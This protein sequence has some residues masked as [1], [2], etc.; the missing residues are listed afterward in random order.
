MA[1]QKSGKELV[2]G[3]VPATVEFPVLS[4]G[5]PAPGD[6]WD[7]EA[8]QKKRDAAETAKDVAIDRK[9]VEEFERLENVLDA[10]DAE[11]AAQSTGG[12]GRGPLQHCRAE[13][14]EPLLRRVIPWGCWH[15]R[16]RMQPR[17]QTISPQYSPSSPPY[18]VFPYSEDLVASSLEK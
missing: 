12:E 8:W 7:E 9:N 15:Q 16:L 13:P 2:L 11:K 4:C 17:R 1:A 14:R 5:E 6:D 10:L 3:L 18:P